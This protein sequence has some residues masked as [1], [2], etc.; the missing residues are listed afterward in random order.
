MMGGEV[1][2]ES[3][4]GRGSTFHFTARFGLA[5]G[6]VDRH[7]PPQPRLVHDLP[8]LIVDDN[9]TNR[10]ILQEM[11]TSWGMR[12]TAVEGG[13]EAME[14]LERARRALDET[15]I[16]DIATV[17]PFHRLVVRDPAFAEEFRVH[18]RWIETE[19]AGDIPPFAAVAPATPADERET[20]VVEVG[21]KRLEVSLPAG[22]FS[23]TGGAA[24]PRP[25]ARRAGPRQATA[26]AGGAAALIAPM[27]GTVVKVAVHNGDTVTDGDVIVVV[28]AMKMEQPLVAHRSGTV[29]DLTVEVGAP[30]TAGMT[31]CTID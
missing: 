20:V 30:V 10:R 17:L 2:L 8:V 28:E 26:A 23:G 7:A 18:T 12:P 3:E 22:L 1:W 5:S 6:P 27:Q 24:S 21:G 11:L 13:R 4:A 14:A 9:A 29:S 25:A 15:V 19:W 31:I 16:E